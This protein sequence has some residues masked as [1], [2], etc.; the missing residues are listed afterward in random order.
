[1]DSQYAEISTNC[2]IIAP[3]TV[4]QAGEIFCSSQVFTVL[5]L[6]TKKAVCQYFLRIF[7]KKI[8]NNAKA[9]TVPGIQFP[10]EGSGYRA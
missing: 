6:Y 4:R 9:A 8:L 5:L 7:S 2:P 10:D 1:M 3:R